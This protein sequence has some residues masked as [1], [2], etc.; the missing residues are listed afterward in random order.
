MPMSKTLSPLYFNK[1]LLH[2]S[3]KWSSLVSGPRLNSSPPGAK[4]PSVVIQQQPFNLVICLGLCLWVQD[5]LFLQ[6]FQSHWIRGHSK[7]FHSVTFL[8]AQWSLG[9]GSWCEFWWDT[10]QLK[11]MRKILSTSVCFGSIPVTETLSRV[12]MQISSL[13]TIS[14]INL[15]LKPSCLECETSRRWKI[16][17]WWSLLV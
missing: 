5:S 13:P 6:G 9:T 2:K 12:L 11:T 7:D 15:Y 17:G 4:N 3:S 16:S 1:T 8:R 10:V 14:S